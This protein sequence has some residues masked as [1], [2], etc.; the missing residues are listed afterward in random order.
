L[1]P[2][3][4]S[5]LFEEMKRRFADDGNGVVAIDFAERVVYAN[6][7]FGKVI[8]CD[9]DKLI[10][11][12]PPF[13]WFNNGGPR[14]REREQLRFLVSEHAEVLGVRMVSTELFPA[15]GN[16]V[17]TWMSCQA[18][19]SQRGANHGYVL[20]FMNP[21]R[22]TPPETATHSDAD[23]RLERQRQCLH[24]IA[25][26]LEQVGI[27]SGVLPVRLRSELW[28]ELGM[29]SPR[30]WEVLWLLLDGHRVSAIA[31]ILHI[32]P[33]TVRNHLQSIYGKVGVRSQGKLIEKLRVP[34]APPSA[35]PIPEAPPAPGAE[36]TEKP[37]RRQPGRPPRAWL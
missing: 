32:S 25:Q 24:R 14:E 11:T 1:V 34:L 7:V 35:W 33:S 28:P 17:S 29:L 12:S 23:I 19:V 8:G 10:G 13:T 22:L 37:P 16:P 6:A 26:E 18:I 2:V 15:R 36:D 9:C 21:S 30:E 5:H 31:G 3:G 20:S 27:P 4:N